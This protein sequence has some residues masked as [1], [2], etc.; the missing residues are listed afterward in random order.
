MHSVTLGRGTAR[1]GGFG[2]VA[3]LMKCGD[4]CIICYPEF[5]CPFI[6]WGEFSGGPCGL[7]S[8]NGAGG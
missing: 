5:Y 6:R 7:A 8:G 3:E 2:K 4:V 1:K